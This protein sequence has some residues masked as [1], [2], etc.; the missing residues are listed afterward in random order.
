VRNYEI[1]LAS[2]DVVDASPTTNSDLYWALRGGGGSNFG[3]VTRFDLAAFPQG[4]LWASTVVY[5][6]AL[7]TTMIPVFTDLTIVG[8]PEDPQAHTFYI[9]TYSP[10]LGGFVAAAMMYHATPPAA[11]TTPEVFVPLKTLPGLLSDTVA[12][13]NV[14]TTLRE[15]QQPYGDRQTWWVTS[16]LAT[17]SSLLTDIVSLWEEAV[18]AL[19]S[20]AEM[21]APPNS[22]ASEFTP[23]FV[24]QPIPVNVLMAMQQ[25]GGNALGLDPNDGPLMI[26]ELTAVWDNVDLDDLVEEKLSKVIAD[27]ESMAAERGELKG[28]VYMNV[29]GY[30]TSPASAAGPA[31]TCATTKSSWP[32]AMSW[33]PL[34]PPT[35]ICTGHCAVAAVPTLA[36]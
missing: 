30:H 5:P 10:E 8:L 33:M 20:A 7:N 15:I 35:P 31:T 23:Y 34:R 18:R 2:G 25:N 24:F 14:S 28:F 26:V 9:M 4:K 29:V 12:V 22:T 36:S 1:V 11:N 16:V 32:Q 3:I 17:K 6:G 21:S 19:L 27:I 13:E